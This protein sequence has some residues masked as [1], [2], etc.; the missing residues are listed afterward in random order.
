MTDWT[1]T[2]LAVSDLD[3]EQVRKGA[4]NEHYSENNGQPNFDFYLISGKSYGSEVNWMDSNVAEAALWE[5]MVQ[6]QNEWVEDTLPLRMMVM[7]RMSR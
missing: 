2:S 5:R 3:L 1:T 7:A 4:I 6:T